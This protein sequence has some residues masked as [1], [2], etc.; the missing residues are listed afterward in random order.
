MIPIAG[1]TIPIIIVPVALAFKHAAQQ[2]QFKHLERMKAMELGE[3][4]PEDEPW[5]SPPRV[6][7]VI[8]GLV[9]ITAM[10]LG[11]AASAIVGYQPG[12]WVMTTLVSVAGVVSSA[13]LVTRHLTHREIM[14]NAAPSHA[15]VA[16]EDDAYDVVGSRG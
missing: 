6:A 8:G 12:V 9:P 3:T 1:M 15:K 16:L 5:W 10:A 4:L 13:V 11:I 7:L 14:K 2:R